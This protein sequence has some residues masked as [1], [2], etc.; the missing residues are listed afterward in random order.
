MLLF[1]YFF[2]EV[3]EALADEGLFEAG[4]DEGAG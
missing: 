2:V 3:V 4:G 1:A